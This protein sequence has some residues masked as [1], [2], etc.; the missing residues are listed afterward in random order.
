MFRVGEFRKKRAAFRTEIGNDGWNWAIGDPNTTTGDFTFGTNNSALN[1]KKEVL[2]GKKLVQTLNQYFT[3]QMRLGFL[4]EQSPEMENRVQLSKTERDDLGI[5]RA[6]LTYNLSDYTKNGFV[7][8]KKVASEIFKLMEATEYTQPPKT[9]DGATTF[10]YEG[11]AFKFY[12]AGHIVGTYRMGNSGKNSV[13]N[14]DQRSWDHD[15]LYMVGS[16][17]FPTTATANPTLTIVALAFKTGDAI[18]KALK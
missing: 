6:E 4:I 5:P 15:N 3:R 17:T 2:F 14:T 9:N 18:I 10:E 12:G 1:Q 8:A 7:A 11:S 13:V 16:G